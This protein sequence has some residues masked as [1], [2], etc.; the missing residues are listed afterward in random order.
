MH[1]SAAGIAQLEHDEGVVLRAYRD[2]VGVWTIGAGL[3]AAS[4]VVV[5]KFGMVITRDEATRLLK[6]ALEKNYEPAVEKVMSEQPQQHEFDAGLLFHFNTGAI[7]RASWVK[8][9]QTG[10]PAAAIRN[11][12]MLWNK[13]GGR[14]VR[15]LQ[16]RRQREADLLLESR[17][18][19]SLAAATRLPP[20]PPTANA[21]AVWAG[22]IDP[23]TRE[24]AILTLIALGYDHR[25]G[26]ITAAGARQ[27]QRD[28][29]LTV[30]GIIGRATVT[31]IQ[32]R[33]DAARKAVL[34]APASVAASGIVALPT[35]VD[36]AWVDAL[37]GAALL[38]W[39][40]WQAWQYRDAIAAKIQ[41]HLP[42]MAAY[43]RSF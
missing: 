41:N 19:Y 28:H 37:I 43:L 39:V 17:Y 13:A 3:T 42:R 34:A 26:Y 22:N 15:G 12:M 35:E 11:A 31:T 5:P 9:W 10:Q 40:L 20:E 36:W 2:I 7:A 33:A 23:A 30:D 25:D 1:T 32:R 24:A 8:A 27:F 18:F 21:M 4:G 29:A 16:L 6:Q 38:V 14:V